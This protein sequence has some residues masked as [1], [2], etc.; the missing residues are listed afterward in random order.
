MAYL[1]YFIQEQFLRGFEEVTE[2]DVAKEEEES[3]PSTSGANTM[4]SRRSNMGQNSSAEQFLLFEDENHN[5]TANPPSAK[6]VCSNI[7]Y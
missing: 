7:K 2:E 5:E 3:Q 4:P 6:K 1:C